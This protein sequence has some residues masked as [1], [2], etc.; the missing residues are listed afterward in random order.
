MLA[1]IL[2]FFAAL[3]S[4]AVKLLVNITSTKQPAAVQEGEEKGQ[5][6]QQAVDAQSVA[7][8]EAAVI[9]AQA[10]A[11]TTQNALV[12]EMQKGEF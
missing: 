1:G 10:Q 6:Q 3:I 4:G 8:T 2:G 7:D 9:R 12:A 5:A 11:P